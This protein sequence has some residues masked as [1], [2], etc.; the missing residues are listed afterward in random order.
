MSATRLAARSLLCALAASCCLRF[1]DL[2]GCVLVL[3]GA[4]AAVRVGSAEGVS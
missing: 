2:Y 4:G 3:V 1:P